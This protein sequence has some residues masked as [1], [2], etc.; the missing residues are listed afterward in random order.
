[1]ELHVHVQ[2]WGVHVP[3]WEVHVHVPWYFLEH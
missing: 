1:M 3:G 2:G